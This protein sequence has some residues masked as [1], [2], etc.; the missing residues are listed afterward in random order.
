MRGLRRDAAPVVDP[1]YLTEQDPACGCGPTSA[2]KSEHAELAAQRKPLLTRRLL[3]GAGAV[4]ALGFA[5]FGGPLLPAFGEAGYPSWDDVQRA[6]G[7]EAAKSG[8]ITRIEG[9]IRGLEQRVAS[10][11]ALAEQRAGEYLVAVEEYENASDRAVELQTQADAQE[12]LATESSDKAARVAAQIYR[13]GGDDTALELFF[14]GSAANAD[15]L[16]A[17]LGSMDK[18]LGRNRDIYNDA[19][20]ARN[21]AQSLSDQ[22]TVARDERDR[23]QQVAEQKMVQAQ[24]AAIAAEA[25]LAEQSTH[26]VDLQAQLAA[27]KDTTNKTVEQYK[28]GVEV[29]RK[30]KEEAARKAKEEADRIARE[31]A[32]KPGGGNGGAVTPSTGWARPSSGRVSSWFGIRDT[33]CVNGSCTS[34]HRGVDFASGCG[35][36][37]YAAANGRV[38]L[39]GYMGQWGNYIKIDHGNG[40][41][42]AYAHVQGGGILV[43]IGQNVSA[44]QLIGRE[45]ATGLAQGCHL[46]FEVWIGGT[47]VDPT[48]WLRARGVGV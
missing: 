22:A 48:P 20:T 33:I 2:E 41:A 31:N 16:L 30:R 12:S 23:L 39:A 44:G 7:N 25:A 21:T 37:I 28:V 29:E 46:H 19:V 8:E 40:V 17:R 34:G 36:G 24:D 45:G 9:L 38:I 11:N 27:L 13:N 10:A 15:D 42:T 4:G 26:L 6:R 5:A 35:G 43:G 32:A 47:R 18:L 14:A 1:A 3:L